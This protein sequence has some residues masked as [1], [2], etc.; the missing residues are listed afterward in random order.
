MRRSTMLVSIISLTGCTQVGK[1]G[2][3]FFEYEC[4]A[5]SDIA[6]GNLGGFPDPVAVGARFDASARRIDTDEPLTVSPAALAKLG[7]E[8]GAFVVR[9][10]GPLSILA[11]SGTSV[12]DILDI[13][14]EEVLELSVAPPFQSSFSPPLSLTLD[15]AASELSV[16]P[17]GDTGE[18]LAGALFYT[19]EASPEGIVE[20]TGEPGHSTALVT[21]V[22]AGQ[23]IITVRQGNVEA[24]LVVVVEAM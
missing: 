9:D 13:R 2:E 19:W 15:G 21:P 7:L 12:V 18:A 11:L 5:E 14:G 3:A 1:L 6:C 8:D 4:V 16:V 23:A 20:L 22:A 10:R 17:L 24:I